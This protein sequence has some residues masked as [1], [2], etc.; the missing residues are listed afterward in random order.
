MHLFTANKLTDWVH[1]GWVHID[2]VHIDWVHIDWVHCLGSS[3]LGALP[4]CTM[5]GWVHCL[6]ALSGC[7]MSGFINQVYHGWVHVDFA[8]ALTS[9][10]V[11]GRTLMGAL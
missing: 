9:F 4:G 7:A 5:F 8:C 3:W 11:T 1:H 10:T 2:W 6:G